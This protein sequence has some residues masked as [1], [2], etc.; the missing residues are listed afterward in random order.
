MIR[1]IV[2]FQLSASTTE[3]RDSDIAA[4]RGALEPL[5]DTITGV[6]SLRIDADPHRVQGHWD[7][8]LVSEHSSW[9]DLDA[10]QIHPA[11]REALTVVA[12]V[13]A[14]KAIV[15]YEL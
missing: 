10:Y 8:A 4:L 5:A 14:S 6:R 7:L 13:V 12:T 2:L 15:D 1:H 3:Q 9:E 11:H